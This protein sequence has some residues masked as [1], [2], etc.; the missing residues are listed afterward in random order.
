MLDT[1][2]AGLSSGDGVGCLSVGPGCV[3]VVGGVVLEA[4]VED[5]DETVPEGAEGLVVTVA[6]GAVLV[7][8]HPGA[9]ASGD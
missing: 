9:G 5:P 1:P 4:S 7:V 2:G 8:E 3:F 6:V